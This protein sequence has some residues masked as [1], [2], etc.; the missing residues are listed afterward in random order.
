LLTVI[1]TKQQPHD[2]G[3]HLEPWQCVVQYSKVILTMET[4]ASYT[5]VYMG[6]HLAL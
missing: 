6:R 2:A 3:E 4:H 1:Q 5:S